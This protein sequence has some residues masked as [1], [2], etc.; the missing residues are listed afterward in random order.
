MMID[1]EKT[2]SLNLTNVEP[3]VTY[4]VDI[5]IQSFNNTY[6][7]AYRLTWSVCDL[8]ITEYIYHTDDP[9]PCERYKIVVT[10]INA[11]GNGTTAQV[12]ADYFTQEGN[13]FVL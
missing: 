4:C 11:V 7:P 2:F 6:Y 10:P 3:D 12:L 1:W 5:N 8:T 9:T 13:K